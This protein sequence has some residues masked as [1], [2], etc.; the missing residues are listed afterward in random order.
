MKRIK[1][2]DWTRVL[3]ERLQDAALPLETDFA[4]F[5]DRRTESSRRAA[6]NYFSDKFAEKPISAPLS[7]AGQ[8]EGPSR[9]IGW[10]PWTLAGVAVA[11]LAAVLLLRPAGSS[12]TPAVLH[13]VPDAGALV[14]QNTAPV[15]SESAHTEDVAPFGNDVG[16]SAGGRRVAPG[17]HFRSEAR[18]I[19]SAPQG[20]ARRRPQETEPE[21]P[22]AGVPAGEEIPDQVGDDSK[23]GDDSEAKEDGKALN[24]S[25][26]ADTGPVTPLSELAQAGLPEEPDESGRAARRPRLALHLQASS[27]GVSGSG[28]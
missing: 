12:V 26:V 7:A 2:Q 14:A 20:E 22:A 13:P 15:P 17:E 25:R 19:P 8:S 1:N 9:R 3:Q 4:A 21:S 28:G 6:G 11:A 5:Y 27:G 24:D 18:T 16:S 23:V 10:W